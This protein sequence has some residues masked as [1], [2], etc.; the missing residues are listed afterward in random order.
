[1]LLTFTPVRSDAPLKV[2]VKGDTVI[3]NDVPF[4]FGAI[5]KGAILPASAVSS[6]WIAADLSR[7]AK[8]VLTLPLKLPHGFIPWPTPPEARKVTHPQ[9]ILVTKDGPVDLPWYEGAQ[10]VAD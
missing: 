6:P 3:L 8:G 1:M 10:D 5:P 7:D 9:P 4:D 2:V